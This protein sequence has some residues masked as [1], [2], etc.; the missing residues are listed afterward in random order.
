MHDGRNL[1]RNATLAAGKLARELM[2]I[3]IPW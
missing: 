1:A 2:L 3:T